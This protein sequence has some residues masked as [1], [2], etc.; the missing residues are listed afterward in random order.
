MWE[1]L[2]LGLGYPSDSTWLRLELHQVILFRVWNLEFNIVCLFLRREARKKERKKKER[3]VLFKPT[4]PHRQCQ[5]SVC[6]RTL[7]GVCEDIL[8]VLA[9]EHWFEWQRTLT[10][11]DLIWDLLE[12]WRVRIETYLW[13]AHVT[14]AHLWV[15]ASYFYFCFFNLIEV[16]H[17]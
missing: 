14:Y 11:V 16:G 13:L 6:L 17:G 4:R 5:L 3:V 9:S 1:R 7:V 10:R 12:T 2:D 8:T 15:E